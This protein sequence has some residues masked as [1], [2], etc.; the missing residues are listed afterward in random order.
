MLNTPLHVKRKFSDGSNT[1]VEQA[2]FSSV[3]PLINMLEEIYDETCRF[4]SI[5]KELGIDKTLV[6]IIEQ[7]REQK[8]AELKI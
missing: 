8:W 2:G 4:H 5:A 6:T 1:L 7:H 3:T